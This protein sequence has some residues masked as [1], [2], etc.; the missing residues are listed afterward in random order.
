MWSV[1][2]SFIVTATGGYLVL[3]DGLWDLLGTGAIALFLGAFTLLLGRQRRDFTAGGE[4]VGILGLALAAPAAEYVVTGT[5][6]EQTIGLYILGAFFFCGSVYHVRYLVRSRK[7]TQGPFSE[8]IRFGGVSL[9][10]HLMVLALTVYLSAV[11][12]VLPPLA[13]IALVPV[14]VKALY[15]VA[16]RS[17][18]GSPQGAPD[19][20]Q[21]ACPH[22]GVPDTHGTGLS[23][24]V[25]FYIWK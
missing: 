6:T 24:G 17:V 11:A 25:V 19:R 16:R 15:T 2:Y 5:S 18:R 10:Y 22:D 1:V 3:I 9:I 7:A 14:T 21:G 4:V 12:V 13:P 8:R 23:A 20:V